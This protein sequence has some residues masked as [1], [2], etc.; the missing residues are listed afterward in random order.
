MV[1]FTTLIKSLH[2]LSCRQ[3]KWHHLRSYSW[4][5]ILMGLMSSGSWGAVRLFLFKACEFLS[6][7]RMLQRNAVLLS[8]GGPLHKPEQR[9]PE[10]GDLSRIYALA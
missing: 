2:P 9:F 4:R 5:L 3:L 7:I 1:F 8:Q 6:D 10:T